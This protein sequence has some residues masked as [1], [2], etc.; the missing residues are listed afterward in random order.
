MKKV[1]SLVICLVL[2]MVS[3]SVAVSAQQITKDECY[4]HSDCP[5]EVVTEVPL[6]LDMLQL[7]QNM[8]VVPD[9]SSLITPLA[10]CKHKS[11]SPWKTIKDA[12]EPPKK[13]GKCCILYEYQMRYCKK[14]KA[15]FARERRT[16]L[17]HVYIGGSIKKCR[18]CKDIIGIMS[19]QEN[20]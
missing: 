4:N 9:D 12:L 18:Y 10:K 1:F 19:L 15:A 17:D 2:I 16:Q 3:A 7:A 8:N 13:F 20:E 6:T 14:C 11:Y 5:T